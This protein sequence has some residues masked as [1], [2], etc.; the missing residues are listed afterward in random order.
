VFRPKRLFVR[1]IFVCVFVVL[2]TGA[3]QLFENR[4]SLPQEDQREGLEIAKLG[5]DSHLDSMDGFKISDIN[6]KKFIIKENEGLIAIYEATPIGL[7]LVKQTDLRIVGLELKL[8][9]RIKS[10]IQVGTHE[11]IEH[12]LESWES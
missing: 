6:E 5:N 8:Q 3:Q 7:R 2:A 10:G 1:L 12:L 4:E 9:K 11:E